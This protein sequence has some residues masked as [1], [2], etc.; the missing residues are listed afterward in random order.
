MTIKQSLSFL[1]LLVF[2][3]L[4]ACTPAPAIQST[5]GGS[6]QIVEPLNEAHFSVGD[7]VMVRTDVSLGEGATSATLM[8]NEE[9]Q[10]LDELS[11]AL[12]QGSM[13]QG[14]QPEAEGTYAL[15]V[16]FIGAGGR[17]EESNIITVIVGPREVASAQ[18][19]PEART[20]VPPVTPIA[21]DPTATANVNSNCRTGPGTVYAAI[22]SLPEGGSALI[23]G[24]SEP[25]GWWLIV[26]PDAI[27]NCWVADSIVEISGD[28]TSVPV[29][30]APPTPAPSVTPT[31][32]APPTPVQ[33]NPSGSLS[34]SSSVDLAWEAVS[35]SAAI[36]YYQWEID[37]YNGYEWFL[38]DSGQESDTSVNVV[39]GCGF[40]YRWRVQAV[41]V[42]GLASPYSAKMEF[43]V[44][45]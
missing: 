34:C 42:N 19:S 13:F 9:P 26:N 15:Q 5:A 43:N 38:Q 21:T 45:P 20:P 33:L 30:V 12:S 3:V 28:T 11:T 18:S 36:D 31:P 17:R 4:S 22:G 14:W 6:I 24:R 10:R 39:I 40:G 7:L 35:H 23:V 44:S 41:D 2:L 29:V 16:V 25:A 8:V 32:T 37:R 27:G 1:L